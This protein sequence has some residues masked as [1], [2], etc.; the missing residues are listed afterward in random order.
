MNER[1]EFLHG[2]NLGGWLVAERWMTPRLFK[3]TD[4]EDEYSLVR[5]LA[6][7]ERLAK[8]HKSFIKK[9][10]IRWL[11]E[12]HINALRIPVGYWIFDGL[13]DTDVQGESTIAYLDQAIKWAGEYNMKVLI[14]LHGAPGG[15]NGR[16]HSGRRGRVQWF[17][18][19]E[20]RDKTIDILTALAERYHDT[21]VVWGIELV[22]EPR[23]GLFQYKLRR[24]YAQA[25]EAII[26]V[27]RPGLTVVFHDAFSPRLMNGALWGHDR[28]FPVIMDSHWYQFTDLFRRV[29][30]RW[31]YFRLVTAHGRLA[32]R[33]TRRQPQVIGEWSVVLSE[34]F[35]RGLDDEQREFLQRKHLARQLAAYT[36]TAGWFYWSYKVEDGGLWSL[37]WL[38]EHGWLRV[39]KG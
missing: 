39:G 1:N 4:A 3:G 2:V 12:H 15:Q 28:R 22:N 10:D 7:R 20:Y 16:D 13:Y 9:A 26:K 24:F 31:G 21:E 37:R 29:R 33:L 8:H 38:I 17:R 11:A 30:P 25:Y 5:E 19:R 23:H 36:H 18:R 14:D 27:A 34:E 6:G 32:H 35:L